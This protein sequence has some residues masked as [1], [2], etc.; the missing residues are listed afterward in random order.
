MRVNATTGGSEVA[1]SLVE[2]TD[3][4][5]DGTNVYVTNYISFDDAGTE[6]GNVL[7]VPI[8]GSFPQVIASN[9]HHPTDIVADADAVYWINAGSGVYPNA[10]HDG[11]VMRATRAGVITTLAS[12]VEWALGIAVDASRVYWLERRGVKSAAK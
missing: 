8:D 10:G 7:R 11:S 1:A 5:S 3:V 2:G 12:I 6:G 9:Q 4:A